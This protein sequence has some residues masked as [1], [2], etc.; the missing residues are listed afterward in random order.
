MWGPSSSTRE[1]GSWDSD[2][3]RRTVWKPSDRSLLSD[4]V[5]T[6]GPLGF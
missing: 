6:V 2:K 3:R 1:D 5:E 4:R